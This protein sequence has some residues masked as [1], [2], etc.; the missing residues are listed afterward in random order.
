MYFQMSQ[1]LN[2]QQACWFLWLARF[3]FHLVHR[4]GQHSMKPDALS[5]Q[6]DH[7]MGDEDN[8][9]QVM[10]SAKNFK[11]EPSGA[12]PNQT[13]PSQ[14]IVA[15]RDSPSQVT[16][17]GEGTKFL[18]RVHNCADREDAVVRALKE[19]NTGKG[20]HCQEWWEKDS[21]VLYQ[22]RVYVPPDG[23]LRHDIVAT[24]HDSSITDHSG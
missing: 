1:D 20:L 5:H 17:E 2:C 23:Q 10:L 12:K 24:L 8:W 9:D 15:D 16:L 3:D 18:E 6:A 19:L 22:G 11:A 7:W 14:S 13:E 4:P 21:L